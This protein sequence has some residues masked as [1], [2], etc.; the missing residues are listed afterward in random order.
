MQVLRKIQATAYLIGP[1]NVRNDE[2]LSRSRQGSERLSVVRYGI[3]V[4]VQLA[5]HPALV[6]IV[7]WLIV[8]PKKLRTL[9]E[10]I[11]GT[12][13]IKGAPLVLRR[14]VNLPLWRLFGQLKR[15]VDRLPHTNNLYTHRLN[16][17]EPCEQILQLV[18]EDDEQANRQGKP[19]Q[20][21]D[22]LHQ[23]EQN[24]IHSS[25][26]TIWHPILIQ[27]RVCAESR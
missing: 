23:L 16:R 11:L 5:K 18:A 4:D 10:R 26:N 8:D 7:L 22:E 14:N 12:G 15:R 1:G 21:R 6:D 17:R 20:R 25:P 9:D 2:I 19:E 13:T 27:L 24:F 3:D